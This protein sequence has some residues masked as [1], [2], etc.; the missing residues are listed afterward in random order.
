VRLGTLDML[1]GLS[2]GQLWSIAEPGLTDPVRGVRIRA[3]E[4]LA[5]V[6]ASNLAKPDRDAFA[7][8]AAEFI[9]AQRL[10]A[11]RPEARMALGNFAARRGNVGE[12]EAEYRAA[13][14][15]DPLFSAA[16]VNLADL[17]RGQGR[18]GDGERVLREAI[19]GSS[20]DASLHHAL[21]LTLVRTKH[22]GAALEELRRAAELDPERARYAYVYAVGLQ[23]AGRRGDALAVLK[24]SLQRHPNDRETLSALVN[25]SRE[26]GDVGS[27]LEYAERLA[28]L[29]PGD[30][31]LSQLIESLR[32]SAAPQAR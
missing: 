23:S 1:E 13:L 31:V 30:A 28:K 16:A 18:D 7:R 9:S 15:L 8:A 10:N 20:Q 26:A 5:S 19:A 27:A 32:R 25:F 29:T 6:P 12:A 24:T 4:L 22:Q 3:A 2:G 17:Y 11:D 14:R 21:G